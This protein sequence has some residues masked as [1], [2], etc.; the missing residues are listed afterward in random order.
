MLG[1][2]IQDCR[3]Q[4]ARSPHFFLLVASLDSDFHG[5]PFIVPGRSFRPD[6]QLV[7]F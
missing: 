3:R 7:D 1:H 5:S 2:H 4:A 6:P